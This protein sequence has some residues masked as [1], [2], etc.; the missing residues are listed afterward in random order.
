MARRSEV[1]DW[2]SISD[3]REKY[4]AYL[5]SREW[6]KK[7]EAVHARAGEKCERCKVLPIAAVHHLTYA[8]KYAE[9]LEDLQ[10]ICQPCHEF[11]HGKDWLDPLHVTSIL[12]FLVECKEER[13]DGTKLPPPSWPILSDWEP[14]DNSRDR[15]IRLAWNVLES[16]WQ[17]CVMAGNIELC[18]GT[19]VE[20]SSF[21]EDMAETQLPDRRTLHKI[22]AVGMEVYGK[23][24]QM[25][26]W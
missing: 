19:L 1:S 21:I 4:A 22:R 26:G 12:R 17:Q 24:L 9:P 14:L 25:A 5:C 23:C 11:T 8:R 15:T 6:S 13:M 18:T 10:A 3:D 7:K 16:A 20:I 2:R